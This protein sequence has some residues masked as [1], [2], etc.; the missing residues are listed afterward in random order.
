MN[1]YVVHYLVFTNCEA[2]HCQPFLWQLIK[3]N[4]FTSLSKLLLNANSCFKKQSN[5]I[6][7]PLFLYFSPLNLGFCVHPW[8]NYHL[9]VCQFA[10]SWTKVCNWY[11]RGSVHFFALWWPMLTCGSRFALHNLYRH[12]SLCHFSE[13]W[14]DGSCLIMHGTLFLMVAHRWCVCQTGPPA[15]VENYY[16]CFPFL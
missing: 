2:G 16:W 1:E 15:V 10:L 3:V 6:S 9:A 13:C 5:P 11:A 7:V 4:K 8:L 14:L 12:A